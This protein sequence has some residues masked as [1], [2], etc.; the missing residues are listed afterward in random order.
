VPG[1]R[2][3]GTD[4]LTPAA[5]SRNTKCPR[6]LPGG[7]DPA[8]AEPWCDAWEAEAAQRRI[9]R[10]PDYREAGRLWIDAQ[11]AARKQPPD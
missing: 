9:E 3:S 1:P 11:Y 10:G 5:L 7:K 2:Q 6:A 4:R 8:V